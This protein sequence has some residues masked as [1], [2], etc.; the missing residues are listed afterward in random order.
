MEEKNSKCWKVVKKS[1]CPK[2]G[3]TNFENILKVKKVSMMKKS[4]C[5]EIERKLIKSAQ[6][7]NKKI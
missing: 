7:K 4:E 5:L 3:K 6:V 2:M 1:E